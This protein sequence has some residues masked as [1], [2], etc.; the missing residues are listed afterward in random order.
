ML[1]RPHKEQ[2][3]HAYALHSRLQFFFLFFEAAFDRL[4]GPAHQ[5]QDVTRSCMYGSPAG[6][7]PSKPFVA[8]VLSSAATSSGIA[9]TSMSSV[10]SRSMMPAMSSCVQAWVMR[11]LMLEQVYAPSVTATT[12]PNC[13]RLGSILTSTGH[14]LTCVGFTCRGPANASAVFRC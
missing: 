10:V 7:G 3:V 5:L 4:A 13:C 11:C 2:S 8:R 12:A 14:V 9:S 1:W 6:P